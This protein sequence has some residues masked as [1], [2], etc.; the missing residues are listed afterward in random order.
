MSSSITHSETNKKTALRMGE[1]ICKQRNGQVINLQNIQIARV[2]QYLK[3][4]KSK[5]EWKI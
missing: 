3:E 5:N 2:V 4:K 1:N